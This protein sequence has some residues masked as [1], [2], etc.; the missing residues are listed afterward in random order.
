M[1]RVGEF[2]KY[3]FHVCNHEGTLEDNALTKI[4][5]VFLLELNS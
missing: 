5:D 1:P 3:I 4:M 2:N